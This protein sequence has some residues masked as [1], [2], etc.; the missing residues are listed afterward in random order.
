MNVE[1][2]IDDKK[3][4]LASI[5]QD[6]ST[7]SCLNR[8]MVSEHRCSIGH[9]MH[10]KLVIPLTHSSHVFC[11]KQSIYFVINSLNKLLYNILNNRN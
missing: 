2:R 3:I 9:H 4:T 8:S 1:K 6:N 7:H 11:C 5:G 10:L